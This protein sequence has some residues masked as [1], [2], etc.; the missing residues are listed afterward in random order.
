MVAHAAEQLFLT[1]PPLLPEQDEL[2][3]PVPTVLGS[4]DYRT[5]RQ[6]L[7]R[8]DEILRARR[9]EEAFVRLCLKQ[10][11]AESK[12]KAEGEGRHDR[13][14]YEGDQVLVQRELSVAVR[15][16]GTVACAT[17]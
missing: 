13:R 15:K 11:L 17:Q 2:Q 9:V 7:E 5:W 8:I 4:V 10:R 3:P 14:M 16:S 1:L 12:Q 6:R